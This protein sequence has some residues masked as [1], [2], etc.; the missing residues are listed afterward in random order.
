MGVIIIICALVLA[1]VIGLKMTGNTTNELTE[2]VKL[3]TNYGD[4]VIELYSKDMPITAGN[5]EKLVQQGFYDGVIFHRIIDGF[6]R[7]RGFSINSH[8]PICL[9]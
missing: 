9:L 8:T 6:C 4:I 3:E 7:D 5:F 2:K 1:G